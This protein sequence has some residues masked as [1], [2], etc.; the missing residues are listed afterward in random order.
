[1]ELFGQGLRLDGTRVSEEG[2][3]QGLDGAHGY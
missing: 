1:M 3:E 2:F